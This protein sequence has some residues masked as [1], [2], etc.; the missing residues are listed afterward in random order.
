MA[1]VST[2]RKTGMRRVLFVQADG[3][4]TALHVGGVSKLTAA[5]IGSH[6]DHLVVCQ[7]SGESVRRSTREWLKHIRSHWPRLVK[8]WARSGD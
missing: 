5:E 6:V 7:E 1:S 8:R 2:N 3:T 4:R